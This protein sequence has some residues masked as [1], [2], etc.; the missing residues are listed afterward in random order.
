MTLC[1]KN[2]KFLYEVKPSL[3]PGGEICTLELE[4]WGL[5]AKDLGGK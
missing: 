1:H 4:L 5:F 3:F 2:N